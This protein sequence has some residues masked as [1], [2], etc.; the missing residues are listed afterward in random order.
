MCKHIAATC[1]LLGER[2]DEDPFLLFH[3]RG[4]DEV[5]AG[6]RRRT[7][8]RQRARLSCHRRQSES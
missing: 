2:F 3:G 5:L 1:Y 6:L 4:Q 7:D 8:G